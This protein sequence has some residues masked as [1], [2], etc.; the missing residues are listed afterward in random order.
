[1]GT[2][3][4]AVYATLVLEYIEENIYEKE[5]DSHFR[6]YLESNVKRFLDNCF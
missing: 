3:V 1:M 5:F 4:V 2:K 6:L